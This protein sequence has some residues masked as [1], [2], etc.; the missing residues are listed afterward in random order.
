MKIYK[1]SF[2]DPYFNLAS[3]QYLLECEPDDVFMLWRNERSVIIGRNQNAYAEIDRKYVT[4]NGIAV[5]RRLTGGGAVFHDP[6]NINYSFIMKKGGAQALDFA[7]FCAPVVSALQKLGV[8][9]ELSGR[10]DLTANGRK[11]S[12]NAQC[13]YNGRVL[14]HGTILFNADMS[15]MSNALHADTEK[16]KSNGVKSVRAR[17]CNL[18]EYLPGFDVLRLKDYLEQSVDGEIT[19]FSDEQIKGIEKLKKE[20]YESWEWNYGKSKTYE[21]TVKRRFPFGTVEVSYTT[22]HGVITEIKISGDYFGVKPTSELEA[23][24]SGKRLMREEIISALSD[25]KSYIHG[26]EAFDIAGLFEI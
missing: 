16:M 18:I 3:E 2:T 9:A 17:V 24:L 20:K 23:A 12:G 25:V 7:S 19:E 13:V 11:F 6:G 22:E 21:K 26:A 1:N 4:D 15:G 5:V 14:H 8:P 10:N